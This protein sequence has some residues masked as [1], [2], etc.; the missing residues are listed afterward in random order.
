MVSVDP[1]LPRLQAAERMVNQGKAAEAEIACRAVLRDAPGLPEA[2]ALL[3]FIVARLRR[4]PEAES[5]LREA[6]ARR[7]DVPH[8]H[9]ELRHVLRYDFRLDEALAEA[10]EAVRLDPASAQFRN[11]LAQIHFDRGEYDQGYNTVLD[12]L[13]RDPE[14]P[15]SHLSL[16]H[17]LLASG[18]FRAGWAE[19]EWRFRSKIFTKALPKPIRPYWNGMPLPGRRLVISTDQGFGDSFQFARYIPMAAAR[20]GE[21]VVICR[22]PQV[23]LLS[24]SGGAGLRHGA[25]TG[26]RSCRVLLAGQHA[27]R[28]RDRACHHSDTDS[29]PDGCS[30]PPGA[31]AGG[32]GS[33]G[34]QRGCA[35][36]S[37]VGW[38]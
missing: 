29:V 9:F 18:N 26:G 27:L 33:T 3:G 23:A 2:I 34:W 24:R 36:W 17:A 12:A 30:H 6:I 10:R 25:E 21:V 28:V 5:L 20:V 8:W 22:Q 4:L 37:G 15:E 38:Q 35:G 1:F 31:L 13:A 7:P 32:T 14:H 19:Y 11:G 16:A